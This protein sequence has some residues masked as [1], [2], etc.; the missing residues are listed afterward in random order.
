MASSMF[1]L[2]A[3]LQDRR[4]AK[5]RREALAQRAREIHGDL[6]ARALA[7]SG[8]GQLALPDYFPLRFELLTLLIAAR[9]QRFHR[10][11]EEAMVQALWDMT[12]EGFD[13][14]LRSRGISD[15]R[16]ASRIRKL[17]RGATGRRDVYILALE[18]GDETA[19][20]NAIARNV[21]D[22][23]PPEDPRVERLLGEVRRIGEETSPAEGGTAL[24]SHD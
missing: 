8:S 22:H 14:S 16:M 19:L 18:Q 13:Y 4:R 6:T 12:F 2:S 21:L 20:R 24:P 10:E 17:L 7:L 1:S 5:Q 3:W 23:A 15:L 11:G 9:L